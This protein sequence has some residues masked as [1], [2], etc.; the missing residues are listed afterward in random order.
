[1]LTYDEIQSAKFINKTNYMVPMIKYDF[2]KHVKFNKLFWTQSCN[3][4]MKL[5]RTSATN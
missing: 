5:Y 3:L 2:Y 4:I 1:M